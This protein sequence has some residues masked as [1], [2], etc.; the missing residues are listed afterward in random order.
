MTT[1]ESS[2]TVA[3][4]VTLWEDAV[5]DSGKSPTDSELFAFFNAVREQAAAE[6]DAFIQRLAET[7]LRLGETDGLKFYMNGARDA[8]AIIRGERG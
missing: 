6:V 7:G 4:A 2:K 5:G 3:D 1:N 8:S